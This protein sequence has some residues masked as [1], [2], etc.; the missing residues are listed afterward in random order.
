MEMRACI[1]MDGE[2]S[3][4]F[5]VGVGVRHGHV[6]LPWLFN[7]FMSGCMRTMKDKVEKLG[8]RLKLKGVDWSVASCLFAD[9]TVLLADDQR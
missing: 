2:L 1:K 5:P 7:I 4:S 3:N 6:M 9:D 8:A